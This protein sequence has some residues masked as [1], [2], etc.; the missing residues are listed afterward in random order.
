VLAE[1]IARGPLS[2][3][4]HETLPDMPIPV[5]SGPVEHW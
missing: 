2:G 5:P 4:R 1:I 3:D